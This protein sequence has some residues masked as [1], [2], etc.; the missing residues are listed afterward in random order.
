MIPALP[1]KQTLRPRNR[2]PLSA[3]SGLSQPCSITLSV[4]AST[5]GGGYIV[6][7]ES[8]AELVVH[9]DAKNIVGDTRA[10]AADQEGSARRHDRRSKCSRH[11]PKI[12]I[13]VLDLAGPISAEHALETSPQGPSDLRAAV[14]EGRRYR[15]KGNVLVPCAPVMLVPL[16]VLVEFTRP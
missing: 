5:A 12:D 16:T 7:L 8:A 13:D 10:E 4:R 9:T 2:C 3:R 1:P 11:G 15:R 6:Q 14:A